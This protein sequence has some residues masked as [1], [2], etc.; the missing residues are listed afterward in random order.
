[1]LWRV[2]FCVVAMARFYTTFHQSG[3]HAY[4]L[5]GRRVPRLLHRHTLLQ[6]FEPV[7]DDLDLRGGGSSG[8]GLSGGDNAEECFAVWSNVVASG[9]RGALLDESALRRWHGI[10]EGET[11][12][13]CDAN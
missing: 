3:A 1:M 9:E 6:L 5:P 4:T 2:N 10:T 8:L 12:L 7:E 11:R 13:C